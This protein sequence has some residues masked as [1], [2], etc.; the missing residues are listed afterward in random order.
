MAGSARAAT[1]AAPSRATMSLGVPFGAH[2]EYQVEKYAPG[3]PASSTVGMPGA[4]SS[5]ASTGCASRRA[6]RARGAVRCSP[7]LH[8]GQGLTR[9]LLLPVRPPVGADD[10]A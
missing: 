4:A 1:T 5:T 2:R 3:T 10:P 9:G 7:P 8:T 6:F